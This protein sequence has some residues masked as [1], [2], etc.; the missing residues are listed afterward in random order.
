MAPDPGAAGRPQAGRHHRL[1]QRPARCTTNTLHDAI[2]S[3]VGNPVT[4]GR[5]ARRP[6][7]QDVVVTPEDGR[8]V[9]A[10]TAPSWRRPATSSRRGSSAST[11]S[12]PCV[13]QPAP[14]P[15]RTRRRPR[16]GHHRGVLRLGP[17]VL[18]QRRELRL[19]P[20]DQLPGR[21][22]RR[23]TTPPRSERPVSLIGVRDIGVQA[24]H[25]GIAV[26]AGP[27][28][29]DQ[30]RLRPCS[31][32]CRSC[33]STAAMWPSPST[34]GS[35]RRRGRPTIKPTSP[36]SSRISL[37]VLGLPRGVRHLGRLPRHRPP[38]PLP[39][40]G[41]M[42]LSASLLTPAAPPDA[43]RWGGRRS[44]TAP[45]S[46]VQSMTTTKTADV[47]GTLAQIYALAA[48]GADIVRCTCNEEG[49]ADRPGADRPP[50][51]GADRR[52]HPLP[53]RDGP[54]RAGG[55][56]AGSAPQPGEPAQG[57]RDQA[58]GRRGPGPGRAHPHRGQCRVAAPRHL[59][60]VRRRHA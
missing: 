27:P 33:R 28:D 40:I 25:Q 24:L 44:V 21:R 3:S 58:G 1:G 30:H 43:S 47:D 50:L 57:G 17:R 29:R 34:N 22:P 11:R 19:P 5:R 14:A 6:A 39:L 54:G 42:D 32:C 41:T 49:A 31:T 59:R 60:Q 45:P 10:G 16:A 13:G 8:G 18:P 55:R 15:W 35:G 12:R 46:R 51:P 52:R 53:P 2:T 4:L 36:S 23:P 38:P 20:G 9:K 26:P 37:P 56:R 7:A 48:A